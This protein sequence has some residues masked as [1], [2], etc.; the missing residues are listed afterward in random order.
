MDNIPGL[1]E[2]IQQYVDERDW[3]GAL[4]KTAEL[5]T[6]LERRQEEGK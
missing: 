6:E 5:Q 1:L 2:E 3:E 4:Q